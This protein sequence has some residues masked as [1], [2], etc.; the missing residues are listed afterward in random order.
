[1]IQNWGESGCW[2]GTCCIYNISG[3]RW[4]YLGI[5]Q[6]WLWWW[7]SILYFFPGCIEK[8]EISWVLEVSLSDDT[9]I[10]QD[11][12]WKW[13][14]VM[15]KWVNIHVYKRNQEISWMNTG[16]FHSRKLGFETYSFFVTA[17]SHSIA[18]RKWENSK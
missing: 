17:Y 5:K 16:G 11:K 3:W 18:E 10:V 13:S 12:L 4:W 1:M 14:M 8:I 15:F 6:C 9:S 2:D 7:R